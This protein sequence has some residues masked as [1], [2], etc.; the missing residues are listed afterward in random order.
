M[1]TT[2]NSGSKLPL[3]ELRRNDGAETGHQDRTL[4]AHLAP[5]FHKDGNA[6]RSASRPDKIDFV[7]RGSRMHA[8]RPVSQFVARA[9]AETVQARG[10]TSLEIT[11]DKDWRSKAYVELASRGVAVSGHQPTAKDLEIVARRKE[12]QEALGNPKV[13]AFVNATDSRQMSDAVARY[14]DLANAF[15]VRAAIEKKGAQIRDE[16]SRNNWVGS[17]KDRVMLS[18]HRGEDLS[19]MNV[20]DSSPSR[21]DDRSSEAPEQ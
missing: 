13:Q 12:R 3:N 6:F 14:P 8:Y 18:V 15:A 21:A 17:M 9:M 5:H 10:W 7:D 11:G 1:A 4:P 16:R 19:Q 2:E 20:R